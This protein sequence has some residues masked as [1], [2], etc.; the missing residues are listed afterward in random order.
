MSGVLIRSHMARWLDT[1]K[2]SDR[3]GTPGTANRHH[4]EGRVRGN[5]HSAHLQT[6]PAGTKLAG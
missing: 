1:G 4:S 2:S 6:S 5:L 3:L